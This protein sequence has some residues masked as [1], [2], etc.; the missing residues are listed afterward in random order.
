MLVRVL[1][2]GRKLHCPEMH[3]HNQLSR[4]HVPAVDPEISSG[5]P[6]RGIAEEEDSRA[7]QVLRLKTRGEKR[8]EPNERLPGEGKAYRA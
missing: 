4:S 5:H 1:S 6:S 8:G 2:V 7:D 3:L